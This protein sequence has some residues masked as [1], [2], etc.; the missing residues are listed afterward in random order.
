M[1]GGGCARWHSSKGD[2]QINLHSVWAIYPLC[3]P[4]QAACLSEDHFSLQP[5]DE[6][7]HS[8]VFLEPWFVVA[9]V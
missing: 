2:Q 8:L 9:E 6:E 3:D 1:A 7:E 5:G 4:R